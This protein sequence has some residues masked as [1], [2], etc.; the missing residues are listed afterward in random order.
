MKWENCLDLQTMIDKSTTWRF[1]EIDF[2]QTRAGQQIKLDRF[3]AYTS[4]GEIS[5][6]EIKR[7]IRN[8]L[9][10]PTAVITFLLKKEISKEDFRSYTGHEPWNP[11]FKAHG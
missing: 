1:F 4:A 5:D 6:E 3:Y 11:D 7:D 2:Q 8:H 9:K 10:D